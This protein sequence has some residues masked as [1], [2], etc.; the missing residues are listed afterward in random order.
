MRT[1][2]RKPKIRKPVKG[3]RMFIKQARNSLKKIVKS[4]VNPNK[5]KQ[6]WYSS[7]Q[8]RAMWLRGFNSSRYMP[9][10][11]AQEKARRVRQ[12]AAGTHGY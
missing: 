10:Q 12:M 6:W 8:V 2:I 4:V 1:A 9:H 5:K 3:M 7:K 11:G